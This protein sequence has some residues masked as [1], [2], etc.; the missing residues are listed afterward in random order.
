TCDQDHDYTPEQQAFH[1][2]LMDRF[3][4]FT[5]AGSGCD[6]RQVMGW[7][8]GNTVTALWNYAQ[9]YAMSDNSFCTTFGPSTPGALNLVSGQT[10]GVNVFD[11]PPDPADVIADTVI[12]DPDGFYD[13][14][15]A[16]GTVGLSGR[17]VGDLLSE[18]GIAWGWFQGG[19]RPMSASGG[20]PVCGATHVGSDGK[21]TRDY[22]AHHEPFQYYKSTA[23]PRHL[24]PTSTA[25][26]GQ[27]ADQANHQY[28]LIDFWNAAASGRLPAVSFLKAP[29]YQNGHAGYSDPLAEQ[30]F[31]VKTINRLQELPQWKRMAV[32]VS[33]DDSDGWYD[34]AIAPIVSRSNTSMDALTGPSIPGA[35]PSGD[36]GTPAPGAYPGRC[37]YGPRL[38]LLV[39]SPYA[40]RN[41]VD[42]ALTDQSSILKFIEDNWSLGRIGDQSFDAKA[43]SLAGMFDFSSFHPGKFILD[44]R[45]GDPVRDEDPD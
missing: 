28:D 11:Q 19:F 13:Q 7:F 42:H 14:C 40:K 43:G 26:I 25:L 38:P 18:R 29:A 45:S 32:I 39:I 41:F 4:E 31:L 10:H 2:G 17:N 12:G 30:S 1:A 35:K 6:A 5:G 8:D 15:S 20:K 22:V 24:P 3:V 21:P 23:N 33:W 16:A 36:C 37:G 44:P 34:H 27:K 9:R